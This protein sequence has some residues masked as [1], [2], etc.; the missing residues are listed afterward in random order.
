MMHQLSR[1]LLQL[2]AQDRRVFVNAMEELDMNVIPAS[3]V[4]QNSSH[5]FLGERLISSMHFMIMNQMNHQESV[6][7]NLH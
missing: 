2:S 5:Q 4:V 6:T 3:S 7:N 1:K